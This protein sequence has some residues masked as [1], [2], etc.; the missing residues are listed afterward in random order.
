MSLTSQPLPVAEF[1]AAREHQPVVD[2]RTPAEFAKGHMPGAVNLPL[3]SDQER[4]VVGTRYKHEGRQAA[5]LQGLDYVGPKMRTLLEQA[6]RVIEGDSLLLYCWRGGMRSQSLAWLMELYGYQTHTLAGGYKSFRNYVLESFELTAHPIIL[7]GKTG[8]GKTDILKQLAVR[9]QTI[10]D[11]EGMAGH[12]GSAFGGIGQPAQPSQQLFENRL[13][14]TWRKHCSAP[15]MWVEDESY[16]VGQRLIPKPVWTQ[17]QAALTLFIEMPLDLRIERLLTEYGHQ[18]PALLAEAI[19]KIKKRLGGFCTQQALAAL[20]RGDL[21][22]CC[23]I[24][25]EHYYDKAYLH[26]LAQKPPHQV[27]RLEVTTADPAQNAET[28]LASGLPDSLRE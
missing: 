20:K 14:L 22:T 25:L 1:M 11:L 4:A 23:A 27:Y 8:S 28:I 15:L 18:D 19:L 21:K 13:G 24:L 2:V 10:I 5:I 9:G 16:Y 3:F 12:K 7:G 26:G 6:D 17:L